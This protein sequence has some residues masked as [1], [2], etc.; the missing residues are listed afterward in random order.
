MKPP[1]TL[2]LLSTGIAPFP[3]F[4]AAIVLQI[5]REEAYLSKQPAWVLQR[6]SVFGPEFLT[7]QCNKVNVREGARQWGDAYLLGNALYT[8]QIHPIGQVKTPRKTRRRAREELPLL[9][10]IPL[11][12]GTRHTHFTSLGMTL[13]RLYM[14]YPVVCRG[15]P[16]L[17]LRNCMEVVLCFSLMPDA[18]MFASLRLTFTH[19]LL[20]CPGLLTTASSSRSLQL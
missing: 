12:A 14:E 8:L 1:Q 9:M 5:G 15:G 19:S 2:V 7:R 20:V 16:G 10:H 6:N 4:H 18:E 13:S 3:A 17:D 11:S